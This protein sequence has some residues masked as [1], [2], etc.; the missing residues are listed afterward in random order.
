MQR[1]A[2]CRGSDEAL[3]ADLRIFTAGA[4]DTGD[5]QRELSATCRVILLRKKRRW[6]KRNHRHLWKNINPRKNQLD[7]KIRKFELVPENS[8]NPTRDYHWGLWGSNPNT[9]PSHTAIAHIPLPE[10]TTALTVHSRICG[11][12]NMYS[13]NL[14]E[15]TWVSRTINN[16]QQLS[17]VSTET[18]MTMSKTISSF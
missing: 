18:R 15:L 14:N 11:H 13:E 17:T 4:Q 5:L 10:A 1:T 9:W 16:Y 7:Y 12:S 2:R 8:C 6:G 3:V